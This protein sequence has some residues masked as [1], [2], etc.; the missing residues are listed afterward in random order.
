MFLLTGNTLHLFRQV[1]V[2]NVMKSFDL[3]SIQFEYQDWEAAQLLSNFHGMDTSSRSDVVSYHEHV[4]SKLPSAND[5]Y[6]NF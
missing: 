5:L 1:T 6:V 2:L 4:A 3:E